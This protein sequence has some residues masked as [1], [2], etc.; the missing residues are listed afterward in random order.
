MLERVDSPG[1][2]RPKNECIKSCETCFVY[3]LNLNDKGPSIKWVCFP[4]FYG[5]LA[6]WPW[7]R[8]SPHSSLNVICY[9][10]ITSWQWMMS[11][12]Y[13]PSIPMQINPVK[14][15]WRTGS[16]SFSFEKSATFPPQADHVLVDLVLSTA[17]T[18]LCG[19]SSPTPWKLVNTCS[20]TCQ[21]RLNQIFLSSCASQHPTGLWRCHEASTL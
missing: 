5:P 3:T 13:T 12:P 1:E 9:L 20:L 7:L 17:D 21:C 8:T 16:W 18:G 6:I 4:K 11:F 10:I 14:A 19:Q 15:H 2:I